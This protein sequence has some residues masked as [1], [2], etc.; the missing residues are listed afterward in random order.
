MKF[1][2]KSSYQNCCIKKKEKAKPVQ[3]DDK[4]EL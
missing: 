1:L 3:P 2:E 4:N